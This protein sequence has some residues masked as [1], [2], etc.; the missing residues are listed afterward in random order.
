MSEYIFRDAPG[1]G[2][3]MSGYMD[4]GRT[5]IGEFYAKHNTDHYGTIHEEVVRCRDCIHFDTYGNTFGWCAFH[6]IDCSERRYC[7]WGE[8]E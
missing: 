5:A 3:D 2:C 6:D 1:F 7:A 4:D 8:R